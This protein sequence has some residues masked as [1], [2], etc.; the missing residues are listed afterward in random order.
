MYF[1][2]KL[3]LRNEIGALDFNLGCSGFIY[4][5]AMSK[6]FINS[7]ISNNVLLI[8]SETYT[9]HIHPKDKS[10]LTIFGDGAQLQ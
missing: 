2:D 1:T 6:S 4:G 10:N 5:L 3:G 8:T 7:G 9:K